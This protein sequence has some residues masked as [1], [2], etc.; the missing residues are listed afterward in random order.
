MRNRILIKQDR[1]M[2]A[3][4]S[5]RRF[6]NEPKLSRS[7]IIKG[8][9]FRVDGPRLRAVIAGSAS[10]WREPEGTIEGDSGLV[11]DR[12]LEHHAPCSPAG[13]GCEKLSQQESA[14]TLPAMF[15]RHRDRQELRFRCDDAPEGEAHRLAGPGVGCQATFGAGDCE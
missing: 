1:S 9:D 2:T 12:D 4:K 3:S 8:E 15:R 5:R 10:A 14:D 11:I 6:G 7:E 13:R